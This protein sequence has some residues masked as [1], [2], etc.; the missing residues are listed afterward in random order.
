MRR[1]S[2]KNGSHFNTTVDDEQTRSTISDVVGKLGE[3]PMFRVA[4]DV[5]LTK[6]GTTDYYRCR[7]DE[8]RT[9]Y[10]GLLLMLNE[11]QTKSFS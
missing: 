8:T 6:F 5:V 11:I 1:L 9:N 7:N 2:K 10:Y 3:I 4:A